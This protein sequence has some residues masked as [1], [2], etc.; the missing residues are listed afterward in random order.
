MLTD[1]FDL[2]RRV[3]QMRTTCVG[4]YLD[5]FSTTLAKDGYALR[6]L[7]N[8][9]KASGHPLVVTMQSVQYRKRDDISS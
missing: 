9:S 2:A 4:A 6:W 3:A 7:F 1:P 5:D 8:A